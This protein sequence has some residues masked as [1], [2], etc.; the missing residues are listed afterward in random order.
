MSTTQH[1]K[2]IC[3][4]ITKLFVPKLEVTKRGP[5][6][7]VKDVFYNPAM[8][9]NR[10]L[11]ILLAQWLVNS[12]KNHLCFLD[13][14]AA[15][16]IRGIRMANEVDGSVFDVTVN[17]WN[18]AAF[19]FIKKNIGK[20]KLKNVQ[21]TNANLNL[22]LCE[23]RFSYID[24]DPFGSPAGF[25]DSAIRGIRNNGVIACTATDTAALCGVYPK[26]CLRRYGAHSFHSFMM[27]EIGMR[28]LLG[29]IGREAAKYDK[30]IKPLV[31]HCTDHYFR[32]YV[33]VVSGVKHANDTM[34][35]IFFVKSDK[36]GFSK[37][38]TCDVGPLWMGFLHDKNVIKELRTLLF[39]KK[40][41]SKHELWKLLSLLEEEA[42]APAFFYTSEALSSFLG[43]SPPKMDVIFKKLEDKGYNVFKTHFNCTGFKTDAA[44]EEILSVFQ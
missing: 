21:A 44:L 3:E 12:S 26:V 28:I 27:K 16:G 17:D 11:S 33:R 42:D 18:K 15:S 25:I 7:K 24:V 14:L 20:I 10:D 23:E 37:I 41:G 34:K 9:L 8:E 2:V 19:S 36:L 4:G 32:V 29:F 38:K 40:L 6:S 35:N 39:E 22:L 43:R 5:G 30:G 13:G 31:C 1:T